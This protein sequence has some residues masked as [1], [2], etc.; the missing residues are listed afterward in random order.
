MTAFSVALFRHVSR[1]KEEDVHTHYTLIG[2]IPCHAISSLLILIYIRHLN[3][4]SSSTDG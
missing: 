2:Q 4:G 3:P 1:L